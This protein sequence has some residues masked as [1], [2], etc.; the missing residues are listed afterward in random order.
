MDNRHRDPRGGLRKGDNMECAN[1]HAVTGKFCGECGQPPL[2]DAGGVMVKCFACQTEQ[3]ATNQFCG[4]CAAPMAP[5]QEDLLSAMNDVGTMHKALTALPAAVTI[6]PFTPDVDSGDEV[7]AEDRL[8]TDD[9]RGDV[10]GK[11]LID[12]LNGVLADTGTVRKIGEDNATEL[13]GLRRDIGTMAKALH[14]LMRQALTPKTAPVVEP[15][16]PVRPAGPK[17][18]LGGATPERPLRVLTKALTGNEV[19]KD[20][21]EGADIRG[22]VLMA[23]AQTARING[24]RVLSSLEIG[25]LQR[26]C[27]RGASLADVLEERPELGERVKFALTTGHQ[28]A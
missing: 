26:F 19:V 14:F 24:Q 5:T 21:R 15:T 3:V 28:A 10:M 8:G 23:K 16:A 7:L 12:R 2:A 18:H 9:E 4:G 13:R 17:S 20:E 1:K 6:E 25:N 27:N 11:A 22:D